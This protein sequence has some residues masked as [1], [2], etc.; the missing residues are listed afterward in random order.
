MLYELFKTVCVHKFVGVVC[1][2]SSLFKTTNIRVPLNVGQC[3]HEK[4]QGVKKEEDT[5][6]PECVLNRMH[7]S[8]EKAGILQ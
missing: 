1:M 4:W 3:Q 6:Q 8:I 7:V 5:G 2:L